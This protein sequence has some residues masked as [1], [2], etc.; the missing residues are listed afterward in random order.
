MAPVPPPAEA[1]PG[2]ILR[3]FRLLARA[4]GLLALALGAGALGGWAF[5]VE[6]AVSLL[7]GLP[8]T[9]PNTAL[10]LAMA[11]LA[12][13][14]RQARLHG[15]PAAVAPGLAAL[16]AALVTLIAGLS[17]G[18]HLLGISLALDTL[19][20]GAEAHG[21]PP[22]STALNLALIGLALLLHGRR[23][24][25]AVAAGQLLALM[26]AINGARSL[27]GLAAP[28]GASYVIGD[29][30][31]V[32]VPSA[33]AAVALG[34]GVL[35]LRPRSGLM[36]IVSSPGTGGRLF[37]LLLP[38]AV[39]L[40]MITGAL[41]LGGQQAGLFSVAVGAAVQTFANLL[42]FWW[43]AR[44]VNANTI[45]R[46]REEERAVEALA[47][48]ERRMGRLQGLHEIDQ[49]INSQPQHLGAIL[50]VLLEAVRGQLGVDAAAVLLLHEGRGELLYTRAS[51]LRGLP[52]ALPADG[53]SYLGL[54]LARGAVV[55]S[56]EAPLPAHARA[57]GIV[58]GYAA[59]LLAGGQVSGV[60]EVGH[61]RPLKVD[62]EWLS[63]LETLAGQ[64]AI[65]LAQFRLFADLQRSNGALM[66][67]Y[68]DTL[69]GWSYALE[70]RD[71]ETRGHTERVTALTLRMAEALG[72]SGEELVNI[73]RGALLHDIGK[74]GIPDAI[75]LKPGRLTE[76]EWEVMRRHP[77]YARQWLAPIGYLEPALPI[78]YSHHEKW[79]G[80][81]YPQGLRGEAIPLAARLFAVVDV[82]DALRSA[83][84]YHPPW[85]AEE[86]KA[87]LRGLA[88]THF[89]PRAV[90]LF[91]SIVDDED[92]ETPA[93]A[94]REVGA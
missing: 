73:R 42:V 25:P 74:L 26:A 13:W 16:L 64:G 28:P 23:W 38:P 60:L 34:I 21:R 70:L 65:A 45:A 72:I 40:P 8:R 51:G 31:A 53:A 43:V 86:V 50:D 22:L 81:G 20:V 30:T 44:I 41:I 67:A 18:A 75:L 77:D 59:P 5:G 89:D 19:L 3:S 93:P 11:G 87:H 9:A 54:A 15:P 76:E 85:P 63:F 80:T 7:P 48:A 71:G 79:D 32:A 55:G 1:A 46:T 27:I 37:R 94:S 62:A 69:A 88:G 90:E 91:L 39:L 83:R 84:P 52:T 4:C 61:R 68:D 47:V 57:D 49:V 78:P 35:C 58:A 12:L 56:D 36:G 17:L 82:W 10:C 2:R 66:R 33:I 14:L 92:G 24:E 29:R 6:A